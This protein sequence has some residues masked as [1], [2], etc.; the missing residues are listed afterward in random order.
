[1]RNES[2]VTAQKLHWFWASFHFSQ[3]TIFH[4]KNFSKT[5]PFLQ[6]YKDHGSNHLWKIIIKY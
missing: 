5:C 4:S 2:F 1:M 3:E 6:V